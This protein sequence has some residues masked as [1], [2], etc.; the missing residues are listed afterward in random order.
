M[1]NALS[2]RLAA[3]RPKLSVIIP[4]YNEVATVERIVSEVR[5]VPIDKE[6]IL[7]DDASTDGTDA[8]VREI[9]AAA[10]GEP[11][12]CLFHQRNGGKTAALRTGIAAATG[13]VIIIQDADLEYDPGDYPALVQPIL[14]G[15]ADVVYGSRFLGSPRRVLFFWHTVG[16]KLLTLLSNI[17]TNLNLTD[18]ETC[19]KAFRADIL[20]AIPIRSKGFGFEPEITAK[21]ARMRCRIFEVPISYS[22]RQYWE[23]KK[24]TWRDGLYAIWTILRFAVID[25]TTKKDPGRRTLQRV[26]RLQR[27]NRHLW[28]EIS[29]YA[30]RRILEVGSGTGNMTRYLSGRPLVVASDVRPEYLELLR[31]A[32]ERTENVAVEALDLTA[33]DYDSINRYHVD[34]VVCLN[35]LE[36]I[37]DDRAVL[38][39]FHKLLPD[40][41]RVILLV[42]MLPALYGSIDRALD[43][44]RRYT[45]REIRDGLRDA[46]F[47]V[48]HL[49]PINIL[50]IPG[51]FLNSRILKRTAVPGIQARINDFL[52]PLLRLEK[53]LRVPV[54]MS[55]LAVGRK[56]P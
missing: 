51:W 25:D 32:F 53:M 28:D 48:E 1:S 42:P 14:S 39:R 24:I 43:H 44:Y 17:F 30:G 46:G 21:V 22:G 8:V 56:M 54:G 10:G 36:H 40:D 41:G 11:V 6:I 16:N 35:V 33:P 49:A 45:K 34:T 27:Y 55:L 31:R 23:G 4:V 26:E 15:R 3:A 37:E 2:E 13:E 38:A 12:R 7:V 50:G 18:M 52:T 5:R 9:A 19:Y 47:A 20:K 29:P